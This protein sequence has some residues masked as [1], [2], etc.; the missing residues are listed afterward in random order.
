MHATLNGCKFSADAFLGLFLARR[1]WKCVI[2]TK[3]EKIWLQC[4]PVRDS[5]LYLP[6][7]SCI[8]RDLPDPIRCTPRKRLIKADAA[9]PK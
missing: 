5:L 9:V 4:M 2:Y 6:A 7:L 1:E 8:I 3:P